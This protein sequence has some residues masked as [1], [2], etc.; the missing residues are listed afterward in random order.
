MI[1]K[2]L[3]KKVRRIQ[4]RTA[5][6][7]NDLL[8]GQYHSVF[9]GRGMEFEEVR[10]YQAGDDVRTIDWNVSARVG[11]P[12]VKMFREEREL[13][14]M[15]LVDVSRSHEFGTAGQL[16]REL[17]TEICATLAFSAIKNNDKVGMILFT[18][19][20]EKFVPPAKGARHVLR[21]VR[22]LLHHQP[23]GRG[24]DLTAVF[25]YL[26][27]LRLRRSVVFMV[28]DFQA[29]DYEKSL[30]VARKRHDLIPI[31][32]T[33]PRERKLPNVGMIEL[34]DAETGE[35]V[36]VDTS[37]R[38][39]RRAFENQ[40]REA[41]EERDRLFRRLNM[42]SIPAITG[43]SFIQPMIRFFRTRGKRR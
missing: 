23:I 26:G 31:T 41:I 11:E 36:M 24:T 14:V 38:N 12:Y 21:V 10:P 35:T 9:R 6:V 19:Q 43:E 4:I 40:T 5:H 28:S 42:D 7:V 3:L 16:K 37:N 8:A 27:R 18:D 25:D 17:A 34:T 22:D 15:L 39:L 32:I 30:R 2:E 33:D 1:P 20:V 13:T 29:L